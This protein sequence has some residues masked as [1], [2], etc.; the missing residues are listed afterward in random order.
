MRILLVI[1]GAFTLLLP[2]P[3]MAKEVFKS[4]MI[5][6]LDGAAPFTEKT[7]SAS[8]HANG[9]VH[10]HIKGLLADTT[11]T[12]LA[13]CATGFKVATRPCATDDKGNLHVN[14]KGL[15]LEGPLASGCGFPLITVFADDPSDL[16]DFCQTGYGSSP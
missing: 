9:D 8:I 13:G 15:G 4:Q 11:Y 1:L 10:V 2:G 12:C 5:C 3:V 6:D 7:G 14:L 16:G